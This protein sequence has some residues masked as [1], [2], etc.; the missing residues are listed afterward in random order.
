MTTCQHDRH[1]QIAETLQRSLLT[2]PVPPHGAR[3]A[4]RYV[5]AAEAAQVGGDWYDA[6][7]QGEQG[8]VLVIGDVMGHDTLAA[9]KMSQVRTLLRG[10][11]FT[12]GSGPVEILRQLDATLADLRSETIATAAVVHLEPARDGTG[13]TDVRWASAGHLPPVLVTPDGRAQDLPGRGPGLVLGIDPDARRPEGRVRVPRGS[14]LLLFT[15]GLVE[16]R[17]E[18]LHVGLQRLRDLLTDLT[19]EVCDAVGVDPERLLDA[20]LHRAVP[21]GTGDDDIA[22]LAVAL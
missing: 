7:H 12:T 5:A 15:D 10:I 16:R 1:R 13:A 17:G 8:C 2:P 18:D 11:A 21:G 4:A 3:I 9:A 6:F 22:L 14:L 19:P 20:V